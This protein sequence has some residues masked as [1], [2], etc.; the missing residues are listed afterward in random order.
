MRAWIREQAALF[1]ATYFG[2]ADGAAGGAGA[3]ESPAAGA[4]GADGVASPS[5][6][7]GSAPSVQHPAL[8][9]LTELTTLVQRLE[10]G[11]TPVA[12]PR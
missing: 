8:S 1:L 10:A 7:A 2:G 4:V 5:A 6:G 12:D 11:L 9:I 3:T